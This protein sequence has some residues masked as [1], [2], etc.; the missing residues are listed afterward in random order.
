[1][2]D[3]NAIVMKVAGLIALFSVSLV[4]GALISAKAVK[5]KDERKAVSTLASLAVFLVLFY[6]WSR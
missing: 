3:F 2:V 4:A 5:G 6:V 1:M